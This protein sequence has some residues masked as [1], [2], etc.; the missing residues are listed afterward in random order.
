M[1]FAA[2]QGAIITASDDFLSA[3]IGLF[4]EASL[5]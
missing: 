5:L 2:M 4:M 3:I 1:R